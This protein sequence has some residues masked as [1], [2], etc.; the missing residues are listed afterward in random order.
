MFHKDFIEKDK[1]VLVNTYFQIPYNESIYAA[2]DITKF[3]LKN[4]FNRIPHWCEAINQGTYA[5]W[6]MLNKHIPYTTVPFFWSN[7][8]NTRISF[9]GFYSQNSKVIF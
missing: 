6:N 2:G 5:G 9:S 7:F 8:F 3:S 4:K 1:T